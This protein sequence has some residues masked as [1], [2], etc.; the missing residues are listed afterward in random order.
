MAVHVFCGP[1]IGSKEVREIIPSA[2]IHD[3]I[4]H[5]DLIRLDLSHSDQVVIIDG[6]YHNHPTIRHKELL[7]AIERGIMVVGASSMGALRAAELHPFGMIG[8]GQIF[9]MYRDGIIEADD[10]VAVVHTYEGEWRVLS[11]ALVNIR[12]T[13]AL[14][15]SQE[16]CTPEEAE[17]LLQIAIALPYA[18]RSWR[19]ITRQ[20][21]EGDLQAAAARIQTLR[22]QEPHRCNLKR[23]D[24]L[25][26]LQQ[27]SKPADRVTKDQPN[28]PARTWPQGWQTAYLFQWRQDHTGT[29]IGE[30]FISRAL[31]FDYERLYAPDFPTRWR[32]YVLDVIAQQ[33][34]SG[35]ES[36]PEATA[37]DYARRQRISAAG[38]LSGR[39]RAAWL[40]EQELSSLA[41]DDAMLHIMV[42]SARF[43][44]DLTSDDVTRRLL[45][46]DR[47]KEVLRCLEL[48]DAVATT[49]Y[50]KHIDH[51]K[52]HLLRDHLA[53]I[54]ALPQEADEAT[55]TAAA[56][57]RGFTSA[58]SAAEAA[59][60]F[61]LNWY[62]A[63]RLAAKESA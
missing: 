46:E 59:R 29:V 54:W 28:T 21:P 23:L 31:Q 52:P 10:E 17:S 40:T 18:R 19:A 1:T 20:T 32:S 50:S 11:D 26:A 6:L 12:H 34:R 61:F 45:P 9:E 42:R 55:I 60:P 37:L 41:P 5:G 39:Q 35:P 22:E 27:V 53:Q 63:R 8:I 58:S 56:R 7:A 36:E 62:N 49:S 38:D 15:T 48:N 14:A 43:A 13:L 2:H 3:P 4:K 44:V 33:Q 47:S 30:R 57:D 24:A 25:T 51:L 16:I